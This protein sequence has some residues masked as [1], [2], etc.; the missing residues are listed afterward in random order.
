MRL[1]S[2]S[3]FPYLRTLV[4]LGTAMK[5]SVVIPSFNQPNYIEYTLK[6]LLELKARA[7]EQG[8]QVEILLFDSESPDPMPQILEKFRSYLDVLQ[9]QKDKGQYD[10]INKG[11]QLLSGAYWTWLNTDD[12]LDVE[13]ILKVFDFLSAN[14][15]ID[16]T[17]GSIDYINETGDVFRS[18]HTYPISMSLLVT[19]TPG[20]FQQGSFFRTEF[21]RKIGLLRPYNCCFDYEYVLRCLQ[22]QAKMHVFDFKVAN[23]RQHHVSKTGSLTPTFIKEQLQISKEYGR[24]SWHFLTGFSHLRLIKHQLFPRR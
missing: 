8:H 10:A 19:R 12:T 15:S 21:T 17:Y 5:F 1:V 4:P 9:V 24:K 7:T 23:F 13:G 6:N 11:I 3:I 22:H 14:P 20:V 2:L 16:Y 18:F